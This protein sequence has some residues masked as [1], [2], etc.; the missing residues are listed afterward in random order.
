M[1]TESDFSESSP[2]HK[3]L[4]AELAGIDR[5]ATPWVLFAGHRPHLVDSSFGKEGPMYHVPGKDDWTDVGVALALQKTIWPLLHKHHVTASFGGH[6]HVYQRHCAFDPS[7]STFKRPDYAAGGCVQHSTTGAD[8]V[9]VYDK[10]GAV[11]NF[12]VGSAGAGFT[13]NSIG[14]KFAE[15]VLYEYGYLRLTAVNETHLVGA[16]QEAQ[17]GK[18]VLDRFVIV[19]EKWA[20]SAT[21]GKHAAST[22]DEDVGG[23]QSEISSLRNSVWMAGT[24]ATLEG[25][26]LIV[27]GVFAATTWR[28]RQMLQ[29][30][31]GRVDAAAEGRGAYGDE[32][33]SGERADEG[34]MRDSR[35]SMSDGVDHV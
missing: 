30:Q 23:L 35:S 29:A 10:P 24:V 32:S 3:F 2:Q 8:G 20:A 21:S 18:G 6:N 1:N 7:R 15:V 4:A 17:D 14:E 22:N 16:F 26:A 13:K 25:A 31:R 11:V 27:A 19:Q 5:V 34:L 33:R 28:R 12:V 9:A